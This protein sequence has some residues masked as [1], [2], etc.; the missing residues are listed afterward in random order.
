[1]TL[2]VH[3]QCTA[4][5][6]FFDESYPVFVPQPVAD[7]S[8]RTLLRLATVTDLRIVEGESV[9]LARYLWRFS[10]VRRR[11]GDTYARVEISVKAALVVKEERGWKTKSRSR[12]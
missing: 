1:M 6:M 3:V 12:T 4:S 10:Q 9:R 8:V 5:T 11:L 7:R 2:S